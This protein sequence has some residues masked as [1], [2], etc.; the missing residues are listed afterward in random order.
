MMVVQGTADLVRLVQNG[1]IEIHTW[2][3]TM[4]NIERPDRLVFDLDPHESL[5]W[6]RVVDTARALRTLLT[7]WKL[8]SFVKTTG[9]KGVHV[10]VPLQPVHDWEQLRAAADTIAKALQ[11]QRPDE[12]TLFMA[13]SKRIGKIFVDTLRNVRGATFVAPYSPRARAGATVSLPITWEQLTTRAT[14]GRYTIR[15]WEPQSRRADPWRDWEAK[16]AR[17]PAELTSGAARRR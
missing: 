4:Q 3:A 10:L 13:K 7:K 2:G 12:L 6:A 16:R 14:P 5:S 9:G 11:V 8:P 17:L 1:A 15:T